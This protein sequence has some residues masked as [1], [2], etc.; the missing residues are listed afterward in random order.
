MLLADEPTGNLDEQTRDEIVDLLEGLWR[1]RG[2]TVVL[3][4]H[5]SSVA[6]RAERRLHIA[7]GKVT[8]R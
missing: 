3:V 4:T 6:A 7:N 8:E 5:D 2:L 1:G